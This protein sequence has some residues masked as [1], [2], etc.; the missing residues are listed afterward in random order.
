[1]IDAVAARLGRTVLRTPVGEANVVEE[2]ARAGAPIGGEGNGGVI[3]PAVHLG[4][5]AP[6]GVALILGLMAATGQKLSELAADLP[7][8]AMVKGKKELKVPPDLGPLA[9]PLAAA[10]PGGILDRRDGLRI[11]RDGE[12]IHVRKSGT[13]PIVRVIAEAEIGRAHV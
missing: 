13:E 8:M 3:L 6:V 1:M 9:D 12:W 4:R 5:D 2:M 7:R 11:S 10:L